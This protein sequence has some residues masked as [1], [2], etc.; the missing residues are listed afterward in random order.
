MMIKNF[1]DVWNESGA[2]EQPFSNF[3]IVYPKVPTQGNSDDCG[4]YV[5]KF[6]ELWSQGSQQPCVLLRSDVQNFRV[7]LA[8][9][10]MFSQDNIEDQAKKLVMT[11]SEAQQ[12]PIEV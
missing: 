7:K 2:K 8:N 9:R 6:M 11:F 1:V 3:H 4:I 5:M 10:L 12:R